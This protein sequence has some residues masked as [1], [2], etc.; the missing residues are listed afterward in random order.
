MYL[1]R[2]PQNQI[3]WWSCDLSYPKSLVTGLFVRDMQVGREIDAEVSDVN[4]RSHEKYLF[5]QQPSNNIIQL[6]FRATG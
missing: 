2:H 5:Q 4:P 3:S 1:H 6:G